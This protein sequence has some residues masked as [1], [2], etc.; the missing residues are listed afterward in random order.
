[1]LAAVIALT[2][3]VTFYFANIGRLHNPVHF[4]LGLD[5]STRL[6]IAIGAAYFIICSLVFGWLLG[7]FRRIQM[8]WDLLM[9]F[10]VFSYC[11][12]AG[13]NAKIK[14]PPRQSPN[15]DLPKAQND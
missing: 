10:V 12:Y 2:L 5:I 9:F 6:G 1:M 4:V 7:R 14:V 15:V 13:A 11:F 3:P 8:A